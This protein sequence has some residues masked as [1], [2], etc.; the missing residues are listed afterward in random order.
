[1]A[2]RPL[3]RERDNNFYEEE[4]GYIATNEFALKLLALIT[5]MS[6][7]KIIAILGPTNT[8][9]KT[10]EKRRKIIEKE[11]AAFRKIYKIHEEY[12][13][14]LRDPQ[15]NPRKYT[16]KEGRLQEDK[17]DYVVDLSKIKKLN[18]F[19]NGFLES[20][21]LLF[22]ELNPTMQMFL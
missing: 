13:Y 17:R 14:F 7:Y 5:E 12:N 10:L 6:N 21:K 22:Q 4:G 19:N 16:M 8:Q 18:V 20:L 1:M 3:K 9:K 11:Q 15:K 2:G